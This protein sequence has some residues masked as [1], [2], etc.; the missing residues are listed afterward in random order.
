MSNLPVID[1]SYELPEALLDEDNP[2]NDPYFRSLRDVQ[3]AMVAQQAAMR[4]NH[5]EMCKLKH[6]GMG[7]TKIAEQLNVTPTTV[8]NV[9]CGERGAVL[10]ELLRVYEA[11]IDGPNIAQRQHMLWRIASRNEERDPRVTLSAVG[12]LNRMTGASGA[13]TTPGGQGQVINIQINQELFP[14][15]ALD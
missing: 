5:V 8:S 1:D 13:A 10:L 11:L 3:R 12:E 4:A 2:A 6:R 15:G 9:T 14:R 7:N